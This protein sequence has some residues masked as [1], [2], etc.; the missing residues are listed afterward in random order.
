VLSAF[1]AGLERMKGWPQHLFLEV[2]LFK[3]LPGLCHLHIW[4][5]DQ[6]L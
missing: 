4:R 3:I 1:I 2:I 6:E 5:R